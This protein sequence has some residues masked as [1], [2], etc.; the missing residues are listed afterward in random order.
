MYKIEGKILIFSDL[1]VGLKSGA[2]SRLKIVALCIKEIINK[3]K[4]EKIESIIFCGDY[5]H[6]RKSIELNTL[7]TGYRML[8][9]LSK[10]AKIYLIT[11]N[12]DLFYKN[13]N[14]IASINIFKDNKN[15]VVISD[16]EEVDINGQSAIFVPWNADLSNVQQS[17]YDL[18]FGHFDISSKYLIASYIEA[19]SKRMKF[20][21]TNFIEELMKSDSLLNESST[22]ASLE[23]EISYIIKE[24]LKSS[25]L[26]GS[27]VEIVKQGGQVYA[28]HIHEH[29]EFNTKGREFIFV[30]SPYQQNFGEMNSICGFYVL[31][32]KN[33]RTFYKI[34][35]VP[36]YIKV[37]NSEVDSAGIDKYDFSIVKNNI[38]QRV[39]DKELPRDIEAQISQKITDNFPF[40]EALSEYNI[41]VDTIL[42][43]NSEVDQTA[44]LIKKSKLDYIKK[45]IEGIDK[46]VLTE[47]KLE[48]DKL[49]KV[50]EHYY[51]K[52]EES[53]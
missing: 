35:T 9:I 38:V 7:D 49:F 1:H 48:A 2:T 51:L 43:S 22:D 17:K 34:N 27:F 50:L 46:K 53:A 19:N 14:D 23:S 5:F 33:K 15:I 6:S 3:I 45:Y 26:V 31:D 44:E 41:K 32:E 18:M 16:V 29:K 11:G 39:I 52:V 37:L 36:R 8:N 30:G 21:K 4:E 24:N 25:D 20:G 40:E 12:H 10:Y 13:T 28:G 47:N 42:E